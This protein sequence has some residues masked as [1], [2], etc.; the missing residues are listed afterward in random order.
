MSC[1]CCCWLKKMN[2]RAGGTWRFWISSC[3][4][5]YSSHI[6]GCRTNVVAR[7]LGFF[8]RFVKTT[9]GSI[10]EASGR[11]K[12]LFAPR[13]HSCV[14]ISSPHRRCS[15]VSGCSHCRRGFTPH[16]AVASCWEAYCWSGRSHGVRSVF[17]RVARST[18][19]KSRVWGRK[20]PS[21]RELPVARWLSA[22]Q[23]GC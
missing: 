14:S 8:F 10:N 3:D 18:A 4:R 20:N 16:S 22:G 23:G 2:L 17:L 5:W 15:R 9:L 6:L 19:R 1:R 13:R 11:S 12:K 7:R 21:G